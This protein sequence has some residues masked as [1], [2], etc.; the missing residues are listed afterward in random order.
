MPNRE[1]AIRQ[2]RTVAS[3]AAM[4]MPDESRDELSSAAIVDVESLDRHV[5]GA[6][7]YDAAGPRPD[8]PGPP[9]ANE[10]Q[11]VVDDQVAAVLARRNLDAA[12]GWRRVDLRLH[13]RYFACAGPAL[14]RAGH[15]GDVLALGKRQ[16]ERREQ[17]GRG[18][19][20]TPSR[21]V[22]CSASRHPKNTAA[23]SS[24]TTSPSA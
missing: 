14:E 13:R 7:P 11:G 18:R 4:W 22:R 23:Q 9:D 1:L 12:A 19:H 3:A 10:R 15:R 17:G 5:G 21:P 6:D 16:H 2:F 24:S 20:F 8:E